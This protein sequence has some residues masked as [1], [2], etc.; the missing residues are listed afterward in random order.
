MEM[1][2]AYSR[3]GHLWGSQSQAGHRWGS[4]RRLDCG[5]SPRVKLREE[6]GEEPSHGSKPPETCGGSFQYSPHVLFS[7]LPCINSFLCHI[8]L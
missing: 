3:A 5:G 8:L 6:E 7:S 1:R 4:Q 2:E